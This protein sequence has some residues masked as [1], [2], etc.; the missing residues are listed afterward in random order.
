M[1][2]VAFGVELFQYLDASTLVEEIK[3]A[4]RLGFET[5]WLGD[6]QLLWRELYVRRG[7]RAGNPSRIVLAGGVTT[8]R[9]RH[10]AV[11]ASALMTLQELSSNRALLGIGV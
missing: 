10:P 2:K 4:E 11:T 1:S 6:S 3:L 9:P 8:P 7:A 5:V